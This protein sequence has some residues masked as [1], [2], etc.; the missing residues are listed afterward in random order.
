MNEPTTKQIS[1]IR[2]DSNMIMKMSSACNSSIC[3]WL[4]TDHLTCRGEG[5]CFFFRSEFFFRTTREFEYLFF[6]SH[7]ARNFFQYLTLGYMTKTL[8]Q[9]I[10]LFLHQN[11][12]IFSATLGS[13]YFFR[14][15]NIA[16]HFRKLNGPSLM[17]DTDV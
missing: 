9:I 13:E 17:N 10:F 8:N 12:N 11:Q 2:A 5:L 1:F 7:K 4:G 14:K 3:I 6:L 16:P 15:K